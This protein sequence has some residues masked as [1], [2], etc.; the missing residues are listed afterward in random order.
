M[1]KRYALGVD[2]SEQG[3]REEIEKRRL[4]KSEG[5]KRK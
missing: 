1:R 2:K 3:R 4:E 5:E